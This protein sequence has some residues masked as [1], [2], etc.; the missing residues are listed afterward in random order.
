VTRNSR[1]IPEPLKRE[2]R[3]ACGFGCVVCGCPFITYEHIEE[4][5]DVQEHQSD[6]IILLC[7][8]HHAEKTAGRLSKDTLR[9]YQL[10]PF[11]K[12]EGYK[13]PYR[14]EPNVWT[15]QTIDIGSNVAKFTDSHPLNGFVPVEWQGQSIITTYVEDGFY[16]ISASFYDQDGSLIVDIHKNELTCNLGVYDIE[17]IG[18]KLTVRTKRRQIDLQIRYSGAGFKVLRAF[19]PSMY[20]DGRALSISENDLHVLPNGSKYSSNTM[21]NCISPMISIKS[22]A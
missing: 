5:A 19:F 1:H 22:L 2:V 21:I 4:W 7:S 10:N 6:N 11:N 9:L 16:L 13:P 20:G 18:T 17:W 15:D 14:I 3:Q 8:T 12:V